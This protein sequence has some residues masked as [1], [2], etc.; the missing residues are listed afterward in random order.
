[1]PGIIMALISGLQKLCTVN[2]I[3]VFISHRREVVTRCTVFY[4]ARARGSSTL[5]DWRC[6]GQYRRI[7]CHYYPEC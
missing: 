6:A 7:H 4:L 1:M 2:L 5:E 3:Q